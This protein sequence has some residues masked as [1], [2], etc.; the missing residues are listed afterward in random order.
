MN[1][2]ELCES[3]HR[4][5]GPACFEFTIVLNAHDIFSHKVMPESS[6]VKGINALFVYA[7]R[8]PADAVA[9]LVFDLK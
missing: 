5:Y 9:L 8:T 3:T 4:K 1:L 7:A 2:L 6:S